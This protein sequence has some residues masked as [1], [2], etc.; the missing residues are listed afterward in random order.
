MCI[1]PVKDDNNKTICTVQFK[2]NLTKEDVPDYV[3]MNCKIGIVP[4]PGIRYFGCYVLCY[5]DKYYPP[6][7]YGEIITVE[8]AYDICLRN[9]RLD[10]IRDLGLEFER[11]REVL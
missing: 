8:E 4:Y 11:E 3:N 9:N 7:S 5:Y 10:L 1:I 6:R 2:D